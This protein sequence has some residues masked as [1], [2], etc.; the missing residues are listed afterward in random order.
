MSR[1]LG[2]LG[3]VTGQNPDYVSETSLAAAPSGTDTR[4]TNLR[5]SDWAIFEVPDTNSTPSV[6]NAISNTAGTL[7]QNETKQVTLKFKRANG[8]SYVS[9]PTGFATT[10]GIDASKFDRGETSN[11][12]TNNHVTSTAHAN[13]WRTNIVNATYT[14][15]TPQYMGNWIRYL[16]DAYNYNE[17]GT[18]TSNSNKRYVYYNLVGGS[19]PGGG[20]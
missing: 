4:T 15:T 13:K 1:S 18:G 8:N 11:P 2:R 10:Q 6:N 16:G 14:S 20:K 12:Q 9:P 3:F 5:M 19:R 17:T 7:Y